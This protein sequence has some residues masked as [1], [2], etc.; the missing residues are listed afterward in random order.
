MWE[1]VDVDLYN[2]SEMLRATTMKKSERMGELICSFGA[3]HFGVV[4]RKKSTPM[5]PTK[6]R[7]QKEMDCLVRER[8]QL[9]KTIEEGHR[10]EGRKA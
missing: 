6:S 7:R 4:E 1:E 3:E 5:I 10:K 2:I 9:K 8:R